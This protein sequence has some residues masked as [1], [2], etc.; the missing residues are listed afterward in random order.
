MLARCSQATVQADQSRLLSGSAQIWTGFP[1]AKGR[2]SGAINQR[3]KLCKNGLLPTWQIR[4]EERH[5]EEGEE[6]PG[7]RGRHNVPGAEASSKSD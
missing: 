4:N 5:G 1:G 2:D 6:T 7:G 3:E